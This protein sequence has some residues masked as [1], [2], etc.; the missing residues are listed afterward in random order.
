MAGVG[1]CH[2]ADRTIPRT[3]LGADRRQE[4]VVG[5]LD[6]DEESADPRLLL[7][8][9]RLP[10]DEPVLVEVDRP[11]E[12]RLERGGLLAHVETVERVLLLHPDASQRA[13]AA[14]LDPEA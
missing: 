10:A 12:S 9:E 11:A 7:L 4:G 6:A 14:R 3:P 5:E 8:V 1:G 13:E 2:G